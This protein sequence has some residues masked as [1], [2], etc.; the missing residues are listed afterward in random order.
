[1]RV[2]AKQARGPLVIIGGAEDKTGEC[3]ILREIVR[4]AGG[5][6]A[7]IVVL[8]MASD[9]PLDVG[10]RYAALFRELGAGRARALHLSTRA[11][12]DDPT[13]V[14]AID[15]AS[16]VFFAGG[17]QQRIVDILAGSAVETVLHR[18]HAEGLLLG[19]TSAGAAAMS[20][21]MIV[22]GKGG[23][24]P[25]LGSPRRGPGMGFLKGAIVDQHFSERARFG[26]LLAMVAEHP[27]HLGLGIDEDTA[28]VVR[29]DDCM[30][31]GRGS[32]TIVD[33]SRM[34]YTSADEPAE[35]GTP[36]ALCDL[37]L[38]ALP[39]GHG[40]SLKTRRP[41]PAARPDDALQLASA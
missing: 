18:R 16:G 21:V 5:E 38:H 3:E 30:V 35:P 27:A 2:T 23:R 7:E 25:R 26:R 40:F 34:S 33:G 11:E 24:A 15:S 6:R 1:M 37:K 39:A 13:A 17:T 32:V 36:L 14:R 12:A 22:E 9:Y 8:A 20:A 19:G 10:A 31:L 4:L 28:L 41:L 29:G